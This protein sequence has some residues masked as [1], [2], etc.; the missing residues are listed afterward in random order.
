VKNNT[1]CVDPDDNVVVALTDIAAGEQIVAG[2]EPVCRAVE[3]IRQGHKIARV[4]IAKNEKVLRYGEPIVQ[5]IRDI[6]VG[7]SVHVHNTEPIPGDLTE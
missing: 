1:L 2:G 6:G 5:A 4:P 7:E 3:S